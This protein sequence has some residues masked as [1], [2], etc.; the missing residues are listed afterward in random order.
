MPQRNEGVWRDAVMALLRI[1]IGWHFFYEGWAKLLH[2]GW[3]SAGYLKASTGPFG[4]AFQWL[5]SQTGLVLVV[6]QIN[7]WVLLLAGLGL[8]LGVFVKPSAI[9]GMVLLSLYYL[10]YPPLFEPLVSG[11][12]EGN[13]LVVNKN[14][15][16]LFALAAVVAYPAAL[17]GLE[18][19]LFRRSTAAAEVAETPAPAEAPVPAAVRG[20]DRPLP[21]YLGPMSRRGMFA[22]MA[23]LPFVGGFALAFLKK[24]G[25]KSFEEV[26]LGGGRR[27]DTYVASATMK[28]FQ[29]TSR[30]ELRG[31]LPYGKIGNLNISRMILGGN[32]IGG[33]AHARDLIYVSKLV[34]A[35]HHRDKIF[36]TFAM[37][38]SCG[39]NTI[40]TNPLLCGVIND[41]WR[42]G[43]RIQFISDCGG[44]DV[45]Q[46][47]QKSIDQGASACYIQG[48]V[49]D[50]LVEERKFDTIARALELIR[51]NGLPAG[52]G[53]HKLNTIRTAVELGLTPDFWMKTLH[54]VDY[55]SAAP[56][57]ENDNRW[58]EDPAETAAYMKSLAQP[59]IAFK[60]LAAGAIE[61]KVAFRWAFEN[62][63]DFICVGMY[64]FQIVDDVNLA[65]NVLNA[66]VVRARPWCA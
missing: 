50:R 64:D 28:T 13:Y 38:E 58:C 29:F 30:N 60:I 39:V 9:S 40:I 22:S 20:L 46:M 62:G 56:Q 26:H 16:E 25:W 49:A 48:G 53:G 1:V 66:G 14:L 8:M 15:V 32:L 54:K 65:L 21:A 12:N 47:I 7:I 23:G 63:A 44:K 37:S 24:H 51:K 34:R 36:Q 6:D 18:R 11:V 59:W 41:Y 2:A 4:G 55:W 35:Y 31:K 3:S 57:P 61:P 52:I 10:A 5:G 42:N 43:G 27:G 17:F 19:I 33:W 45:L